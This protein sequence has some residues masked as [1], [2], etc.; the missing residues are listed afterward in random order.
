MSYAKEFGASRLWRDGDDYGSGPR[1]D[2][3][4][5]RSEYDTLV[6]DSQRLDWLIHYLK[7]VGITRESIDRMIEAE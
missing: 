7:N 3:R 4:L 6:S 1:A 2:V 5:D